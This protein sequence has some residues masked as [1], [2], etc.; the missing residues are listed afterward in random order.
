MGVSNHLSIKLSF[1]DLQT[2]QVH[3]NV[4]DVQLIIHTPIK[5]TCTLESEL[6]IKIKKEDFN[7]SLRLG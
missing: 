7:R 4:N 1:I 3:L 5:L 2:I 6:I